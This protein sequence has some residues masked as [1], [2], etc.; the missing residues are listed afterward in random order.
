MLRS[1]LRPLALAA[2]VALVARP[3]SAAATLALYGTFES[4][5]VVA[6][7][8]A[9][10]DPQLDARAAV[11]VRTG[12][13]PFAPALDLVRTDVTHFVGSLFGL[14][15][16]TSYDVRVVF[17][18]PGGAL[19]GTAI[20]GSGTTRA[21]IVVPAP[22][23]TYVAAPSGSGSACTA[24]T[25]CALTTALADVHAGEAVELRGGTYF[26]GGLTIPRSGVAG[27]PIVVR[28]WP[29]E[30]PVLDGADPATFVW[31]AQGGGVWST[32]VQVADPH[33]VAA[34]G[35]RLYP[36]QSL[37]DLQG[38]VWG[39]PGFYASGTSVYVR[40]AADANP[41][42]VAMLVARENV[43][44]IV[45]Q[46][47]VY[48]IGL[49]FRHYGQGSYAKAIYL[50]GASDGLVRSCRFEMCDL[51]IGLKYA[52]HR[53]VIEDDDFSD[54][55]FGWP[56]EAVKAGSDLE[57]GGIRMYDPMTG[58]GTV[59]RRNRFHDFFDGFGVC[60]ESDP[61]AT[62]E[63]DVVDNLVWEVGDDGMETDGTCANVRILRNTF[64][65]VLAGISLAP[66]YGGPVYA[67]RNLI[68][69]TGAGDNSWSGNCF[70][71]NSDSG[72][73]GAI[74]LYHDTCVAT[75]ADTPALALFTPGSWSRWS[76][77]TT[78]GSAPATRSTT[79]TPASRSISTTT[80][81]TRRHPTSSPGGTASGIC[82]RSPTSRAPRGW[83]STASTCRR[84]SRQG[85][86]GQPPG[87]P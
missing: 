80:R 31:T 27:A 1:L 25:P 39:M 44:F 61:G 18:D 38:L 16:G 4:M 81:S 48:V 3:G 9:G 70:K 55:I 29:G 57:T 30:T 15:A 56:W 60:P 54:T 36:Y 52:A 11:S 63:T 73:S 65:D 53:N 40:L 22:T 66:V 82:A 71:L 41:N 72:T 24:A 58:R 78:S 6:T 46:D 50:T 87:A 32:T 17:T 35:A 14:Q 77:A 45:D 49:T 69:A 85:P 37:A 76:G 75:A 10:D 20:Q 21:E 28:A 13:A 51:G 43:A 84:S 59:I 2:L 33:L 26:T 83:S 47:F 68:Y 67:I 74:R 19:D 23:T 12:A 7:V 42:G 62:N 64:H 5:G 34:G 79:T 86:T 8:A